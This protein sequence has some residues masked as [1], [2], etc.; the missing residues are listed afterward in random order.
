MGVNASFF[1]IWITPSEAQKHDLLAK[2]AFSVVP[3]F[4][5]F[6]EDSN[7]IIPQASGLM[8]HRCCVMKNCP[9]RHRVGILLLVLMC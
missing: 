9:R 8:I 5:R 4:I 1:L 6:I 2:Y 7:S 3:R